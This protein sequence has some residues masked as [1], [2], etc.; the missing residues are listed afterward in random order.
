MYT[1]GC[2]QPIPL[3]KTNCQYSANSLINTPISYYNSQ[4]DLDTAK[5][6][7]IFAF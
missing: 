6:F 5:Y 7:R 4:T 1:I 3:L 2:Y